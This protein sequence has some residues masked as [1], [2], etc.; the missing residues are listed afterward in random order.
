MKSDREKIIEK[1][2]EI[3][4]LGFV[5]SNRSNNTGIGKTFEDYAGVE[6]NNFDEPDLFGY[7]IK[8]HR[9][10]ASSYVTLFTKSP[11]FPKGANALLKDKYGTPYKENPSLKKLHTSMFANKYNNYNNQYSFRLLNNKEKG[12]INIGVFNCT[13]KELIDDSVGYTYDSID[14][15]LKQKLHNLFYVSA[16]RRYEGSIEFFFFNKAEIYTNPS[17]DNFLTLLDEGLVMFDLRMGSYHSGNNY[18]KAHD[19]GSGFRILES[20]FILLYDNCEKIE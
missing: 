17:L 14:N 7:E 10:D 13:T 5:K 2:Y 4:K 8:S 16:E 12:L 9:E 1:F 20:N 11:T 18:G 3:K 6:E 19:H 15:V